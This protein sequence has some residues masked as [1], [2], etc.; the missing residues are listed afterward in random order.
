M[1]AA[2]LS[3]VK[4]GAETAELALFIGS[5]SCRLPVPTD[6]LQ[7]LQAML[8]ELGLRDKSPT[9]GNGETVEMI[10]KTAPLDQ[11]QRKA[12]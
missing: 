10:L 2:L 5:H 6:A 3:T 11:V 7:R 12:I 8:D 4:P 1:Q 9:V